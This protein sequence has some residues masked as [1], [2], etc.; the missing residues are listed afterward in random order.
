MK[1]GDVSEVKAVVNGTL[2][3]LV[4]K[5]EDKLHAVKKG[6]PVEGLPALHCINYTLFLLTFKALKREEAINQRNFHI[7]PEQGST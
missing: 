1:A 7:S 2:I 5:G 6:Q 3:S 4:G